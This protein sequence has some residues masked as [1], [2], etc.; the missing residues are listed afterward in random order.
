MNNLFEPDEDP[1]CL[2]KFNKQNN[3]TIT[4]QESF[5]AT[6]Y[7]VQEV[8]AAGNRADLER[9]LERLQLRNDEGN[10]KPAKNFHFEKILNSKNFLQ[11]T[12]ELWRRLIKN[13]KI[14]NLQAF[15]KLKRILKIYLKNQIFS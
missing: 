2:E 3:K 7:E 15:K 6:D 13:W 11:I 4:E 9:D 8:F 1:Y 5:E 10:K 14:R 12:F